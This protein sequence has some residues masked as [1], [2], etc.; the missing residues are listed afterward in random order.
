MPDLAT[1]VEPKPHRMSPQGLAMLAFFEGTVLNA[2][3]DAVGVWTIGV[4]HSSAA[5]EPKVTPG[6]KITTEEALQILARDI[7]QY[8]AAVLKGVKV[9]I[10]QPEFDALVSLAYNIGPGNFAKADVLAYLN[11]GQAQAAADAFR[12]HNKAQGKTLAGLTTRREHERKLFLTG[13]YPTPSNGDPA[14]PRLELQEG[15]KSDRVRLVQAAL[16][17]V[18]NDPILVDG[19]FGPLTEAAVKKFQGEHGLEVDGVVGPA[20]WGRLRGE[21]ASALAPYEAGAGKEPPPGGDGPPGPPN[22]PDGADP[23]DPT[24]WMTAARG[25]LGLT[26]VSGSGNAP[27]IL[28]FWK[29]CHLPFTDDATPWCAGFVGAMLEKVGITSTRSGLARSYLKW[30]VACE[31]KPGAVVVFP[32]AGGSG[33][34]GFVSAIQGDQLLV[35]GG[36]QSDSVNVSK[37][38]KASALGFRWPAGVPA[39]P[40]P[41]PAA[42]VVAPVSAPG[43]AVAISAAPASAPRRPLM[44]LTIDT[45]RFPAPGKVAAFGALVGGLAT[46]FL[47]PEIGKWAGLVNEGNITLVYQIIGAAGSLVASAVALMDPKPAS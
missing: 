26:E 42:P 34:V 39:A 14:S 19:E 25:Y 36:N 30:G 11:A 43:E 15:V 40:K 16:I 41:A 13:I 31:A 35:L 20:T 12:G 6:L 29:L 28:E 45:S 47:G 9:D 21:L 32:R 18:G 23:A 4:G 2:Y 1:N 27:E 38:P 17:L 10:T 46:T 24:P 44:Q 7:T 37:F 8:E 3:R 22:E 33:H 5:G